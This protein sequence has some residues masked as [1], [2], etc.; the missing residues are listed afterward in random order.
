M[1]SPFLISINFKDYSFK[2]QFK[3]PMILLEVALESLYL[4]CTICLEHSWVSVK[5]GVKLVVP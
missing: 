1:S 3:V 2:I 5:L 4:L